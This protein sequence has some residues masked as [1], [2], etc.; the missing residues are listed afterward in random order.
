VPILKSAFLGGGV[1]IAYKLHFRDAIAILQHI[2]A[3]KGV[4][5]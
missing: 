3:Q 5:I 4:S 1:N 2:F